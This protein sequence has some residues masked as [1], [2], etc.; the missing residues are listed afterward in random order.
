MI[1]YHGT[2]TGG[3]NADARRFLAGRSALVSFAEP[4]QLP[5]VR[6]VC[7]SFVLDNG[8]FTVW[9]SGGKL[10]VNGYIE[11][12]DRISESPGFD[13][14]RVA[15]RGSSQGDGVARPAIAA[16]A[17]LINKRQ[18]QKTMNERPNCDLCGE[19][20]PE[21]EE[22]FKFHGHSGPCPKPPLSKSAAGLSQ[23]APRPPTEGEY[24]VGISFNPG[25]LDSVNEI[26]RKAADLIDCIVRHGQDSRCSAIAMTNIEQG[27]MWAVKSAT[28]P[29]RV[30]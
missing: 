7:E 1:L 25:G 16:R 6:G 26:K 21:G 10:N 24:L 4:K 30:S 14:D 13:R 19:P 27:A 28:K 22:M 2:P 12:V 9:K 5:I 15:P 3:T 29:P 20:M 17:F 23:E 18:E 8:A 11:W